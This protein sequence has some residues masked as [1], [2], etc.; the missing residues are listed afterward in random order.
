MRINSIKFEKL[1][2]GFG[3]LLNAFVKPFALTKRQ[4]A[5]A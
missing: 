3:Q 2:E 5:L 1:S 4:D